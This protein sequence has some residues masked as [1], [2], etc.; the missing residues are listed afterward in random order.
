MVAALVVGFV[1][2]FFGKRLG[3][4]EKILFTTATEKEHDKLIENV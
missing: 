1:A 4:M 3:F 2:K